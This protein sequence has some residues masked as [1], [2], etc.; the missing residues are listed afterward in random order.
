[1]ALE[2]VTF[3]LNLEGLRGVKGTTDF[4]KC[5][6]FPLAQVYEDA[7]TWYEQTRQGQN[8]IDDTETD[9]E[10]LE[11]VMTFEKSGQSR[12]VQENTGPVSEKLLITDLPLSAGFPAQSN[13]THSVWFFLWD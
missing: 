8:D 11:D 6:V 7:A 5:E 12:I 2:E 3:P 10:S 4:K 9:S 1:M 13:L